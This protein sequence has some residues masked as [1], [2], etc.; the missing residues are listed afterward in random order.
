[1]KN[2]KDDFNACDDFFHL[3]FQCHVIPAALK[4]L[5]V[6]TIMSSPP[7]HLQPEKIGLHSASK[8][9]AILQFYCRAIVDAFTN[10][11]LNTS[12]ST[13]NTV[14][15]Y[16]DKV[17]GYAI[18]VGLLYV[19]LTD[20]IKEGDGGRIHRCW[21]FMF[22]L[23]RASGRTNYTMEAFTMLYSH[24]FLLS[25][26]VAKQLLWSRFINTAGRPGKNMAM[27]LHMEHLNRVCK[28]ANKTPKAIQRIGKAI[29]VLKAVADN[30]DDH[31]CVTENNKYHTVASADKDRTSIINE[32]ITHAVFSHLPGRSHSSFKNLDCSIFGKVSY[33]QMLQWMSEHIPR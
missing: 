20:A 31:T 18:E 12:T 4:V 24:S 26:R 30:F 6:D 15:N 3:V 9:K 10:L 17:L 25:P 27:D 16:D 23:F 2:P 11:Q 8:R 32:L 7:D 19:E 13:S 29:G 28:D 14:I 22:P 21:K 1:M 33:G 5:E